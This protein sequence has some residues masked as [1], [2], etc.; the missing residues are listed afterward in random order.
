MAGLEGCGG[1]S[2]GL[3]KF[4]LLFGLDDLFTEIFQ[5]GGK[6]I[7]SLIDSV[8]EVAIEVL[9]HQVDVESIIEGD[10]ILC[11]GIGSKASLFCK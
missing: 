11:L 7:G 8:K 9:F 3:V 1:G 6:I 4:V 5:G 10:A 2:A